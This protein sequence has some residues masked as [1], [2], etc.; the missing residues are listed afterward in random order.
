MDILAKPKV[1]TTPC[2]D[3]NITV[4]G[5]LNIPNKMQAFHEYCIDIL[6]KPMV[7]PPPCGVRYIDVAKIFSKT[8]VVFAYCMDIIEKLM[9]EHSL[10]VICETWGL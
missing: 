3:R 5:K 8:Q 4:T 9:V 10:V 2:G 1:D 6:A 7:D